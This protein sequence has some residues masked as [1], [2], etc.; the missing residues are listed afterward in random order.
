MTAAENEVDQ[1]SVRV[2]RN[3]RVLGGVSF[4][5]DTSSEMLY[6]V[7]PLYLTEVLLAPVGVVGIVEGIAEATASVMKGVSGR[8]AD[9]APRRL[10]FVYVGYGLAALAKPLLAVTA[11]WH[12][13]L[14][15]R[16][17]DRTGKGIRGPARDGLISDSTAADQRGAA[18]GWHKGT[19]TLGAVAGPLIGLGLLTLGMSY[20]SLFLLATAPAALGVL[21][22]SAVREPQRD[23]PPVTPRVHSAAPRDLRRFLVV[24][25]IFAV[26]NSSNAFLLLRARD[27]GWSPTGVILLY[28]GFNVAYA[29]IA[30]PAGKL[31]DRIGRRRVLLTG[32]VASTLV[33]AGFAIADSYFWAA[34]LL[35][36]YGAY[37]G[38]F[39]GAGR[40]LVADLAP[41][42]GLAGAMGNYQLVS[43]LGA[44][45][46]SLVAGAL[47]AAYGPAAPFV[48][49]AATS[50]I[51]TVGLVAAIPSTR[52]A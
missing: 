4:L 48:Y 45:A 52:N 24:M 37:A 19:D 27:L 32:L 18:Y 44:L 30:S 8:L 42:D 28:V 43:G 21:L 29:L 40:A 2:S 41:H 5:T 51:A 46:A 3:V 35:P 6:P 17:I 36:L 49:G 15:A 1:P 9:R 50:A 34:I 26:G 20:T 7:I 16:L 39:G 13:V 38:A 47:W 11:S 33:Y 25:A 14:A 23:P 12:G 22:L 31:S 10:P